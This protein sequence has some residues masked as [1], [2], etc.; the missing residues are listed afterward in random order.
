MSIKFCDK[1]GKESIETIRICPQCG[2]SHFTDTAP[3]VISQGLP[4]TKFDTGRDQ[5]VKATLK[6]KTRSP[7]GS[8]ATPADSQKLVGIRGWLLCFVII[9]IFIT[10]LA[11]AAILVMEISILRTFPSSYEKN[12]FSVSNTFLSKSFRK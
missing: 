2:N 3:T 1:C 8:A 7:A 5:G 12:I 9:L 11:V 10:P 6:P 4:S